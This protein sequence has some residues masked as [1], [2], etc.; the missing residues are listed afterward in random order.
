MAEAVRFS[1]IVATG[2]ARIIKIAKLINKGII[3]VLNMM[4]KACDCE[5]EGYTSVPTS[6]YERYRYRGGNEALFGNQ[7][8]NTPLRRLNVRG[9]VAVFNSIYAIM[10]MHNIMQAAKIYEKENLIRA[11]NA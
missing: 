7:K 9:R 8:Q 2:I 4:R 1:P 11:K 6:Y 5:S 10:T 3:T